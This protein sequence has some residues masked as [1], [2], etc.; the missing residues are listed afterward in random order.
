MKYFFL[1]LFTAFSLSSY[2]ENDDVIIPDSL[3][4]YEE[5]IESP[6]FSFLFDMDEDF[7][8]YIGKIKKQR[9][10]VDQ[11]LNILFAEEDY[12]KRNSIEKE[13]AKLYYQICFR[14]LYLES[15]LG[16]TKKNIEYAYKRCIIGKEI[17]GESDI[18]YLCD[19][20]EL[21]D[22]YSKDGDYKKALLYGDSC[23]SLI[24]KL[25]DV[26]PIEY[27]CELLDSLSN[28]A[29]YISD[30]GK[31]LS[32]SKENRILK[33]TISQPI[34]IC[35]YYVIVANYGL[36]NYNDV[37]VDFKEN[38]KESDLESM[39]QTIDIHDILS[40]VGLSYMSLKQYD[41]SL[42]VFSLSKKNGSSLI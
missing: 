32:Y 25:K 14:V 29:Y 17:N 39:C 7:D 21:S 20:Q 11:L 3:S 31:L 37:I 5:I 36:K 8:V 42:D 10:T 40:V 33:K 19:L 35:N 30:F 28:Y 2:G 38:I 9:E 23:Y 41:K 18:E 12:L 15:I 13:Y 24:P 26:Y 4:Y 27:K 34:G 1:L 22:A 16:N 6:E